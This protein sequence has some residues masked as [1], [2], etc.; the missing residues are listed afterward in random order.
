MSDRSASVSR[1]RA[2]D[3]LLSLEDLMRLRK[4]QLKH[5]CESYGLYSNGTKETLAS[6]LV[7]HL[8]PSSNESGVMNAR[9]TSVDTEQHIDDVE[10][11]INGSSR[12]PTTTL[13]MEE[14]RALIREELSHSSQNRPRNI[15]SQI[16][17][18]APQLSPA[19]TVRDGPATN[20]THLLP[21][22]QSTMNNTSQPNIVDQLQQQQGNSNTILL[23]TPKGCLP[24]LSI[25]IIK[26]IQS[27]D[28][29]DFNA[30]LPNSLY[31]GSEFS[32]QFTLTL[33]SNEGNDKSIAVTPQGGSKQKINSVASWFEAWNVFIQAMIK[34]HPDLAPDLLSYQETICNFQRLYPLK[35]WLK[36]DAAFRMS[37]GLNKQ[38]SWT[39]TDDYAINKFL[40]CAYNIGNAYNSGTDYVP[41]SSTKKCFRCF[42]TEH[43]ASNFPQV[44]AMPSLSNSFRPKSYGNQPQQKSGQICQFYNNGRCLR[45]HCKFSH[46]CSM[47]GGNHPRAVCN[48]HE[49]F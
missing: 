44:I 3:L 21:N 10:S 49:K 23:P 26:A 2:R 43:M 34:F 30:L 8:Q 33:N 13:P 38:L 11:V 31:D 41:Q 29:V 16:T 37:M 22:G 42:S 15:A 5:R 7:S 45:T 9:D 39:R 20:V 47:C 14:L 28:Y 19:S 4:Q 12:N 25:K 40:R 24:P 6:R 36:Y 46:R 48:S 27:K 35:A 18:V 17:A 1:M 32:N